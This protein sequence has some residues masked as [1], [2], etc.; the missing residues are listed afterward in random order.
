[1]VTRKQHRLEELEQ[2]QGRMPLPTPPAETP[3]VIKARQEFWEASAALESRAGGPRIDY[4]EN[5]PEVAVLA[6]AA[7]V[8]FRNYIRTTRS[9]SSYQ[10]D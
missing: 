1:M 10:Q 4:S 7:R 3:E 2:D 6:K 8:A 5:D 9:R